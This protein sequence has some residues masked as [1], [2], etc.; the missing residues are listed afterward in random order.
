MTL[1]R[2]FIDR[3]V[4]AVALSVTVV[5]V[6]LVAMGRLAISQ[7]PEVVPPTVTVTAQYPGA[8]A[9]TIADTV[10][11]PI[12]QEVNGV[13]DM[14]YMSS[15]ATNDGRMA[16]T[17]TFALGTDLD[18]AQV[19]VQNRVALAEPR[20]P[21][22]VRRIGVTVRKNAPDFLLVVQLLSPDNSRDQL[23]LSNYASTRVR[24]VLLR[25]RG[26]G[27]ITT[28]GARDYSMR[29]WLDPDRI[30][31]LGLTAGEVVAAIR[32]QNVQVAGGTLAQ[33]P[34]GQT[35][36]FQPS[37]VLQGRLAEPGQFERIVVKTGEDGRL[38]LL[39]DVARLELGAREYTT[40]AY[41]NG[42][43]LIALLAFQRAGTNAIAASEEVKAT[44]ERIARDFP[45][46]VEYRMTYNPTDF[47]VRT[48]IEELV[49]T[50]Y[51]AIILV[52]LVVV[53]FLQS[54]RA[55]VIPLLAVPVS[56]VGTF[57]AMAAL[58]YTI[59]T[60]TLFALV[61]AVGIVVD[62]AI[63][64]VENVERALGDGLSPKEAARRTM[65]EVGG[66]LVA[67]A[68]VLV[69]VFVPT[70]FLEGI[71][72]QFFRQFAVVIA[73]ATLI[74]AFNSLTLSPALAGLLLR[75][76]G[77]GDR[78]RRF[79]GLVRPFTW[80]GSR[81][82]AAFDRLALGYARL[83]RGAIRV[84]WLMLPAY[85]GLV[86]LAAYAFATVPRGFVPAT[87][88][89]Y[90]IVTAQLPPGASLARTDAVVKR[91]ADEAR[92]VEGV[93]WA[94]MFTGL[95]AATNTNNASAG[96]VFVQLRPYEDRRGSG[97]GAAAVSSRLTERLAA[98]SEAQVNVIAPPTVRGIGTA[99]GFSMR[100]QDRNGRG[101][102]LLDAAVRDLI[103]AALAD[104]RVA[105][106]FTPY[107]VSAPQVFVD[108]DRAKA[109]MLGV[110]V[111]GVFEALETYLGST[112]V[113]DFNLI[114]RT[115]QVRAQADGPFRL[116]V[117]QVSRLRARNDRGEM[118]PLGSVA[119]F[120]TLAAPDRVPRYNLAATAE[121][122]G[123][124]A[125]G[126]SSEQAL[127][128]MEEI[129]RRVLPDG[130]DIEWTDLSFQQRLAG[131]GGIWIF[132]LSVVFVFL[133]LA[134]QYE[135]WSLPFAIVLIVPMCLLAALAGLAWYGMDNN[136]L[137]QVGLVVLVGLAAKN[138]ILIVE[139]ARQ[140]EGEGAGPVEAVVEA[141]RLRLRPILM[142]S[143]A[144]I[145]GVLPLVVARG[146]GA[147][148]R[149]AIGTAVFFGMLGV[150]AFGLL[151]T[152]VF[153]VLIRHLSLGRGARTD[154]L[155]A[156]V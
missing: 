154:K 108:V 59:N 141:A 32:A 16:L 40:N 21:E 42:Q 126:V 71:P 44:M 88:Q 124:A 103:S 90:L 153:Y 4:F 138:A 148:L 54:G 102:Q 147:E 119:T 128:A 73:V 24:D 2:F 7:Y 33:P 51:E 149:H 118:V 86:G 34:S 104:G 114:G 144:F 91:I 36:A 106:A 3:P 110:P 82:N 85:A 22:E 1:G 95:A 14:L 65:D 115:F 23:Y 25:L 130:F 53:V 136:I 146:A 109:Q 8:S 101:P 92:R 156:A 26:V 127:A 10:A 145:L 137:T 6:G 35:R 49:H 125:A 30:S 113:N 93:E 99:G 134:A 12:E 133:V 100:L 56:L 28:L 45:P 150:T 80:A 96:T 74:S 132:G 50:V 83:V 98:L 131:G 79:A 27:D 57:A 11:T 39:S 19:L 75:S 111:A 116:D 122:F 46:G 63:V 48:S 77:A 38:V 47:F 120:K 62:D 112:Y 58:G 140:L 142:T 152:P 143:F 13:D 61:L 139:F 20:L 41:L 117:E 37:L 151:F 31:E 94:H 17:V 89:G 43:P 70:M 81:F 135:S 107:G 105:Q 60:L 78:D 68:L 15:Q 97:L 129:A 67:I 55:T 5:I 87:D 9:Q 155:Q 123:E 72:G 52:V 121:V 64:V 69:S 29:V 84:R 66:A 18:T 76:H